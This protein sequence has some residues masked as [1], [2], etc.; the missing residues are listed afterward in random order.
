MINW[1]LVIGN[2]QKCSKETL[3]HIA[4]GKIRLHESFA[5]LV[6]MDYTVQYPEVMPLFS[7]SQYAVLQR[8]FSK[9]SQFIL[10]D[11]V[12]FDQFMNE[13]GIKRIAW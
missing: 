6:L 3:T 7:A 5:L 9:K 12:Y 13:R 2:N 11:Q 4:L 8:H 1:Y 10:I